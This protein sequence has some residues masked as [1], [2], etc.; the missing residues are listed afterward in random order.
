MLCIS[1]MTPLWSPSA[2][3]GYGR[4]NSGSKPSR[5]IAF[6]ALFSHDSVCSCVQLD[7]AKGSGSKVLISRIR[8]AAGIWV[9]F[10]QI[11]SVLLS[12]V[13]RESFVQSVRKAGE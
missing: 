6:C 12:Q 11:H 7:L 13:P 2:V 10:K 1:V 4:A 9:C 8:D 3:V 5:F